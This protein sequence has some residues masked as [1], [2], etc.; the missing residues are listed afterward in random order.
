ME[1]SIFSSS[2]NI[3][4]WRYNSRTPRE[5]S[6]NFHRKIPHTLLHHM[7]QKLACSNFLALFVHRRLLFSS[8]VK[9]TAWIV[10]MWH[11]LCL[12]QNQ[13]FRKNMS[14]R[15]CCSAGNNVYIIGLITS[16]LPEVMSLTLP[17]AL[18][19]FIL[20]YMS[21]VSALLRQKF[22]K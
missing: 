3:E 8:P 10:L 1:R 20:P 19:L 9:V 11:S 6:G 16:S 12:N 5:N 7:Q 18:T 15:F 22:S 14:D 4:W 13:N 17:Y 21:K 2:L